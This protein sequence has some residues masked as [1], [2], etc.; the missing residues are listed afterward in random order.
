MATHCDNQVQ[1]ALRINGMLAKKYAAKNADVPADE[2]QS[3]GLVGIAQ[4]LRYWKRITDKQNGNFK[5]FMKVCIQREYQTYLGNF[6]KKQR[7]LKARL[8]RVSE[9]RRYTL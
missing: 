1:I 4:G 5:G 2:F 7:V 9:G 6:Q 3:I 8:A